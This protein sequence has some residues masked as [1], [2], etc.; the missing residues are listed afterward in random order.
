MACGDVL[1]LED[2]QT[3]KKHQVFE[4]EVITGKAGGVAGGAGIDYATNPVTGQTQKTLPAVLRDTGF[5]PASFTFATGGTLAVG[6]SDV[7][8]LWPVSSGGDG[9]YYLWKGAYPKT[10]PASSSPAT[11]GGVSDAGWLPWGDITLRGELA[12]PTGASL[13]GRGSGNVDSDL[14]E[15]ENSVIDLNAG[16]VALNA[17]ISVLSTEMSKTLLSRIKARLR[18]GNSPWVQAGPVNIL[19]A[20]M[21]YGY[22]A[23][24]EN[25]AATAGGM[26]YHRWPSIF[27]RMLSAEFGTGHYITCNP[28]LF[29]YATDVDIAILT[30]QSSNWVLEDT[31]LYTSDLYV[32]RALT[33]VNSGGYLEYTIPAT[34]KECWVHY[35][36]QPGGGELSISQ[37]GAVTNVLTCSGAAFANGVARLTLV[38]NPQ[39]QTVLRLAKTDAGSGKVGV[40]AVSPTPGVREGG[41]QEGG[42]LNVFAA[43]G[44]R[45]QD[46]SESVIRDSCNNAAGLVMAL[47]FNDN[48]LNA[49][50][51]GAGQTAFTQ[52]IDWMIQYCNQYNTPLVVLDC[53]WKDVSSSFTRTELKR[54]ADSAGGVYVPLPDMIKSGSFPTDAY[55]I[56]LGMWQDAAHPSRAG[57]KWI[58]E[59]LS[60]IMGLGVTTK[61]EAIFDNDYWISMPLTSTYANVSVA[62]ARNISSY[63]IGK[64]S[65]Q[66]RTQLQVSAGGNF[67]AGIHNICGPSAGSL[68]KIK[69]PIN[70]NLFVTTKECGR[71]ES[72]GAPLNYA[73]MYSNGLLQMIRDAAITG[74]AMNGTALIE[75]DGSE[76]HGT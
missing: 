38:S 65:I 27:A 17:D 33:N 19:G 72:T 64:N 47:G 31:G 66:L 40:C 71:S 7:V 68:F 67:S 18:G 59:T 25:G 30:S 35:V 39:G 9:Q 13:V 49:S 10:I 21:A 28:N 8:V 4:A 20:S 41:Q 34:F 15:L 3:A 11:T 5:R 45:L 52:R 43:P 54:L 14:T 57:H 75:I 63:K 51:P 42:G 44:R 55:R 36:I 22:F 60:K 50:G 76:Y 56:G 26:F 16:V 29:D 48:P 23:S 61:N 62:L 70:L 37:N 69:P 74:P 6:D 32:G 12:A 58:A 2:L 1:S 46:L 73:V 53:S 24:Y